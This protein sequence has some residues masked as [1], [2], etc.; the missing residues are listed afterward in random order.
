AAPDEGDRPR[1]YFGGRSRRR[2]PLL[3]WSSVYIWIETR[4]H[5]KVNP[6]RSGGA[7]RQGHGYR[8]RLRCRRGWLPSREAGPLFFGGQG[9]VDVSATAPRRI[10]ARSRRIAARRRNGRPA[11]GRPSPTRSGRPNPTK[12]GRSDVINLSIPGPDK[13][14]Q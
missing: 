2:C 12:A 13:A 1:G 9:G 5:E 4:P 14:G 6:E 7:K 10:T 3:V 8:G 11:A